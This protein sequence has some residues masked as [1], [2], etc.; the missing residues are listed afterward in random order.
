MGSPSQDAS[1]CEGKQPINTLAKL[2]KTTPVENFKQIY[3]T[4]NERK[5]RKTKRK[6]TTFNEGSKR[7][8]FDLRA[9][10]AFIQKYQFL[11]KR[12]SSLRVY[13]KVNLE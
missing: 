9:K 4:K 10:D 7:D 6:E 3:L 5:G 11:K 2:Q 12:E 1:E 13:Q 8:M